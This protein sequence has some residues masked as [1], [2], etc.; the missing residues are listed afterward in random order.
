[1]VNIKV[2]S[3][4]S[5]HR[6]SA[7]VLAS[8]TCVHIINHLVG[9][10]GVEAHIR[11]MNTARLVYRS[12]AIE[13]LLLFA[14]AIQIVSGFNLIVRGW[15]KR[16]GSIS[17][18]QTISGAY[19]IF[20]LLNHVIAVIIGRNVLHL[21]TNFY[22]AAVGF[23]VS[24]FQ[25]FFAPYY[26]LAVLCLFVHLGCAGYWRFPINSSARI[27]SIALPSGIGLVVSLTIVLSLAGMFYPPNIPREYRTFYEHLTTS[28]SLRSSGGSELGVE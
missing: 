1:M 28:Q 2:R 17:W 18:L 5:L 20:F 7:I 21:D 26:F 3:F 22:Y 13:A 15:K 12:Q 19:L 6:L 27:L 8:Y 24:P 9:V 10:V 23:H 11:F 14:V 16:S 4:I 25:F